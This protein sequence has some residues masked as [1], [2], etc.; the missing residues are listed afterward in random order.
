[1]QALRAL[2][3]YLLML[4]VALPLGLMFEKTPL[5]VELFTSINSMMP[6]LG[7]ATFWAWMTSLGDT[8]VAVTLIWLL[9][10]KNPQSL[11]RLSFAFI[12][13]SLLSPTIKHYF[14]YPR[15]LAVLG[16]SVMVVGPSLQTHGYISGHTLTAFLVA[17]LVVYS[18]QTWW[19]WGAI[20]VA[21]LVGISRIM[22]GAHW[23]CDVFIGALVGWGAGQLA[24][25]LADA[26]PSAAEKIFSL[27][28][29]LLLLIAIAYLAA[30][31]M[32][33]LQPVIV[34]WQGFSAFAL[35]MLLPQARQSFANLLHR[36]RTL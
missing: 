22:V 9:L 28:G 36:K 8:S 17:A 32:S 4:A 31:K 7:G 20:L 18:Y 29:M 3:Q 23:P 14:D 35:L 21:A 15:P 1:M 25:Y 11:V 34:F 5:N 10:P 19:V 12:L 33:N 16:D 13:G 26:L 24:K 30:G 2:V 27:L 6:N